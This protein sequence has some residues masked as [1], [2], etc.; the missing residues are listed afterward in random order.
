MRYYEQHVIAWHAL[1]RLSEARAARDDIEHYRQKLEAE[2]DQPA[3]PRLEL[4]SRDLS[5]TRAAR[6]HQHTIARTR[7]LPTQR[8]RVATS[9]LRSGDDVSDA[10]DTA[11]TTFVILRLDLATETI[12]GTLEDKQGDER[13]FWG[14]LD[15]SGALEELSGA[16]ARRV[17]APR[18]PERESEK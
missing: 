5:P 1:G 11:E 2:L 14:W 3:N 8:R 9:R 6:D 4:S 10:R 12:S 18:I 15:L 7:W 16:E 13:P 17:D